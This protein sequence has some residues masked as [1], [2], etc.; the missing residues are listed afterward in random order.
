[1]FSK[2]FTDGYVRSHFTLQFDYKIRPLP[3]INEVCV[4]SALNSGEA[5]EFHD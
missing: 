3:L 1:M 4:V 5:F 2:T